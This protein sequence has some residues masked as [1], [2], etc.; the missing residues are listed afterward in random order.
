[1]REILFRGKRA[2]TGEWIEGDL[3]QNVDYLKIREQEKDLKHIA[4]SFV[5]IP[6]TAGQYTG[7]TDKNGKRIFEGDIVRIY[8]K[9]YEV[10]YWLGQFFVGINMPI[11]YKRFECEVIGNVNDNPEFMEGEG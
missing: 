10:Q 3:L 4:R 5:I 11:A 7:L 9:N 8:G 6:E 1:M 2:D